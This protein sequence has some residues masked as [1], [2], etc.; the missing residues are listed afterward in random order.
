MPSALP[1]GMDILVKDS[2]QTVL[3]GKKC[4]FKGLSGYQIQQAEEVDGLT[5]LA[6]ILSAHLRLTLFISL[7]VVLWIPLLLGS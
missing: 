5:A 7:M 4:W 6:L 3:A 1:L 2:E